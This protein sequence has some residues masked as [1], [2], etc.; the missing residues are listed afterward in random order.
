VG[1]HK[2]L[3]IGVVWCGVVWWWGR[4]EG[5][6]RRRKEKEWN[7]MELMEWNGNKYKLE[8]KKNV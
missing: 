2:L 4:K 5:E 7:G 3:F 6:G 8:K 1:S